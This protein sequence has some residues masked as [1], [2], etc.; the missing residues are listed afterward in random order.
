MSNTKKKLFP[1]LLL[2]VLIQG[3]V[4][5]SFTIDAYAAAKPAAVKKKVT[6]YTDSPKYK[7]ELKNVADDAKL[8]YS[9][10][11]KSVVTVKKGK[12]TPVG[13]GKAV[14]TVKVKQ[15]GKTYKVKI[16]FTVKEK[17]AVDETV[18]DPGQGSV[19]EETKDPGQSMGKEETKDPGKDS[20]GSEKTDDPSVDYIADVVAKSNRKSLYQEEYAVD[21]ALTSGKTDELSK[22][23]KELYDTVIKTAV[24]LK[25]DTDLET[26]E[27]IHAYLVTYITYSKNISGNG[28]H[29]LKQAL[30]KGDAVCDGYAKSFYF[31]TKANGI[32]S[33]LV[34]GTA[35][36]M[37]GTESHAW[38]KVKINNKWYAIDVTWDDP[39]PEEP[40][41]VLYDYY[42]VTDKDIATDHKWDDAGLPDAVSEDFGKVYEMYRDYP[43]YGSAQEAY[44]AVSAQCIEFFESGSYGDTLELNFLILKDYDSFDSKAMEFLKT[45]MTKYYFGVG[46]SY[47]TAGFYGVRFNVSLTHY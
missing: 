26:V 25:G 17:E 33:I 19:S 18:K 43:K 21:C 4:F 42:L 45:C 47:E 44:D 7:I 1:A 36:N 8:K 37:A 46:Y 20:S 9:S 29:T 5:G 38:N 16:T 10:A 30:E 34:G 32:E 40:G 41:R 12:V 23:E 6:L 3:L 11:D 39:S 35:T 2:L 15:N 31:L 14:V 13:T 22:S 27:N 24:K 28:V